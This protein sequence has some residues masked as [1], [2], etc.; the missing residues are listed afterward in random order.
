MRDPKC[1]PLAESSDLQNRPW[2]KL[3][4]PGLEHLIEQRFSIWHWSV[5]EVPVQKEETVVQLRN[6]LGLDAADFDPWVASMLAAHESARLSKDK[7]QTSF[8]FKRGGIIWF[9][10]RPTAKVDALPIDGTIAMNK[11]YFHQLESRCRPE[12]VICLSELNWQ[13][14]SAVC[15]LKERGFHSVYYAFDAFIPKSAESRLDSFWQQ[16]IALHP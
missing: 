7:F 2:T 6:R 9:D 10:L 13:A 11:S 5:S 8:L 4:I 12:P 3:G 15:Y 14:F 1:P 16:Q